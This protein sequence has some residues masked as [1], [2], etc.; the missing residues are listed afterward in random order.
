[1][2]GFWRSLSP[3]TRLLT[4]A[5]LCTSVVGG[6]LKFRATPLR[7]EAALLARS[8]R[9]LS[10]E[11]QEL[12]Q[13]VSELRHEADAALRWENYARL[14]AEQSTGRSLREVL[15]RSR[16]EGGLRAK[17]VRADFERRNAQ[18]GHGRMHTELVFRGDYAAIIQVLDELD[19]TFPPIELQHVEVR[20]PEAS[21]ASP[22]SS[23]EAIVRGVLHEPH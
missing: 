7:T 11:V 1:M 20:R 12:T 5:V 19:R 22:V 2:N 17:V 9:E 15:D 23:V 6:Y 4:V 21:Q 13:R 3:F 8:E 14:L 16:I 18:E 10:D